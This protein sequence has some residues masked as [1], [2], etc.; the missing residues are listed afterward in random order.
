VS[1]YRLRFEGSRSLAV[2]VATE[3][4]DADGV[5]LISS[6][7]PTIVSDDTVA[8]ELVVEGADAAVA[9]AVA[10]VRGRIPAGAAIAIVDN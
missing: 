10:G 3:L 7:S 6:G 8:L 1:T 5:E 4:A 2:R 9:D